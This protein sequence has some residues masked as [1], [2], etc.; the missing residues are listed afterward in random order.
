MGKRILCLFFVLLLI[1]PFVFSSCK[2]ELTE[3][4]Q[5]EQ[6]KNAGDVALTLSLWIPTNSDVDDTAFKENLQAIEN[7]INIELK[8]TYST[9]IKITAVPFEEYQQKLSDHLTTIKSN[10]AITNEEKK[11]PNKL[12]L[13][14][15]V[16]DNYENKVEKTESGRYDIIYPS[17]LSNQIDI[18][19]INGKDNYQYFIDAG[20]LYS[21]KQVLDVQTG[22]YRDIRKMI[23][24]AILSNYS[25]STGDI[26][27]IPNNHQFATGTNQKYLL[28]NKALFAEYCQNKAYPTNFVE[29]EEFINLVGQA[30]IDGIVPFVGGADINNISGLY[31]L[32]ELDNINFDLITGSA[33]NATPSTIFDSKE[34]VDYIKLYKKLAENSY[35][36]ENLADNEKAAVM[37]LGSDANLVDYA[38]DYEIIITE[39]PFVDEAEIFNGMFA[40]STYSANYERALRMLYLL[41]T[42]ADLITALQYGI[43]GKTYTL[44]TNENDETVVNLIK[45]EA[46]NPIYDM[47]NLNIGNGYNTYLKDGSSVEAWENIKFYINYKT[48]KDPYVNFEQ[49]Y[50]SKATNEQKEQ[51]KT[52]TT[53]F[54]SFVDEVNSAVNKMTSSEFEQF[55]TL[56]SI[57]IDELNKAIE[58]YEAKAEP[59]AEET[60]EYENNIALKNQYN[61]NEII[62]KLHS[63][64][65]VSLVTLY[66]A[67]YNTCK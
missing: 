35:V 47:S 54:A 33:S 36:N 42:D 24:H 37:I 8:R 45:D 22:S 15:I 63:E 6:I 14:S 25:N 66:K 1:V 51:L 20:A 10:T 65:F 58:N 21:L 29:C 3:E 31:D 49:N 18:F 19:Y 13:P 62:L 46:G 9:Q 67:L 53:T 38:E 16:A 26:Y 48:E 50:N 64:E 12:L 55:V 32:P 52:L 59:T 5:I 11:D 30:Q 2:K 60:L 56:Y 44:D 40:I 23:S 7:Q 43:E 34:F 27:A 17:V 61:S 57:N 4:E 41:Q 39:A 28:V